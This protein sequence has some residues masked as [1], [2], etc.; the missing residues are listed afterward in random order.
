ME[1]VGFDEADGEE[2]VV[3]P[4][5]VVKSVKM[6][7]PVAAKVNGKASSGKVAL[8]SSEPVKSGKVVLNTEKPTKLALNAQLAQEM[9]VIMAASQVTQAAPAPAIQPVL[10]REKKKKKGDSISIQQM[11]SEYCYSLLF[12]NSDTK[13]RGIY[14]LPVRV[15][16]ISL[17]APMTQ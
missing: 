6:S 5:K 9:P 3:P 14:L 12:K 13:W 17:L 16:A 1:D 11:I 10:L 4:P 15:S 7:G 8:N 2:E